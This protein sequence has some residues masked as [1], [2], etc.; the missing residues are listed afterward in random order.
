MERV[1][2]QE[3]REGRGWLRIGVLGFVG[4]IL[5]IQEKGAKVARQYPFTRVG[6]GFVI[7]LRQFDAEKK[8][9][10]KVP[11][12][13]VVLTGGPCGGKST[14]MSH[15][16]ERMQ[17]MGFQVYRVPE[18]ASLLLGSGVSVQGSTVEQLVVLQEGILRVMMALEDAV[19]AIA[20]A[21]GRPAIV[22]AD[23]GTM[24]ASAYMPAGA[25]TALLDEHGW[26]TPW[27]RDR[28]YE[29]VIHLVT[30]ADG[31]EAFY[32]TE[33]NAVR[34]ETPELARM[35][36]RKV[37]DAWVGHPCLRVIDNSTDFQ[38][39]VQRVV[40]AVCN[41]VG[42]PA[43]QK[44]DRKFLLAR[45]TQPK[46]LPVHFQELEIDQTYLTSPAGAKARIQRRGE[47]GSYVYTHKMKR[48]T[49]DGK[50]VEVEYPLSGRE[51]IAML[52]ESDPRR[53]TLKKIRRV[54]LWKNHYFEWDTYLEPERHR[55]IEMLK[56][57]VP[58]L[59]SPLELPPFLQVESEVTGF[60]SYRGA[61]MSLL[62]DARPSGSFDVIGT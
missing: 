7:Q 23:R 49:T 47:R 33:N 39:K 8:P 55:H 13:R 18:T 41:V 15:I 19:F 34:T 53:T 54:F 26:T 29:A 14:S 62:E 48:T 5:A 22:I 40:A 38:E 44:V 1:Y 37:R 9:M 16:A 50:R 30:A 2:A 32:T 28:R 59:L 6:G 17:G 4:M 51:Y 35:L 56:V 21:S 31:A 52:A 25:W 12:L 11:V 60:E 24:D 27:L 10:E 42:M 3:M 61:T 43:P 46:S 57:E 45:G 36:D 58:S 20:R